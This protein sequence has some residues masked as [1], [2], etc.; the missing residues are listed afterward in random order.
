MI[1]E[2]A[3]QDVLDFWFGPSNEPAYGRTRP[4]WFRKDPAF[5]AQIRE[6]FSPLIEQALAEGLPSWRQRPQSALAEVIVLDQ[7]TR[8]SFRDSPRAFAGDAIALSSAK[9]MVA[10]GQ[11][12]ALLPV[13]R[14]FAYLPFEHSED[15]ADQI[16][17]LRLFEQ[18]G[19][20]A[21]AF[22]DLLEWARRHHEIV[23]R[24][25]RFPHRNA[26]LGREN[27]PEEA[28]FLLQPGSGF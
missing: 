13:Q 9:T 2:L 21:P 1:N 14:Q 12:A 16:E 25:G 20:Q 15:V 27:T 17:S 10:S 7:F 8:N 26:I 22:A 24:F 11:H 19:R 3:A 4:A 5:D 28:E 6:R 18:L 23:A